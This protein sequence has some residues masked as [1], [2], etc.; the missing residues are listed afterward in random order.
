MEQSKLISGVIAKLRIAYPY[1]FKELDEETIIGLVKMYQDQIVGYAPQVVIKSIDQIIKTSKFMPT[2]AEILEKCESNKFSY[3]VPIIEKMKEAGYFKD[4]KEIEK[5]YTFI[6]RG[7]IPNWL[8]EDMKK[9][10]YVEYKALTN[11][12]NEAKLLGGVENV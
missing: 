8:L 1:Y 2:I 3:I 7:I 11:S 4:S 9:Y 10:G 12:S 5:T 6:E